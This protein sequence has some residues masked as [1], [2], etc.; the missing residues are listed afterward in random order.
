MNPLG[1]Y[2]LNLVADIESSID[3]FSLNE[4]CGL[5]SILSDNLG[6]NLIGADYKGIHTRVRVKCDALSASQTISLIKAM[7]DRIELKL[8]ET[9][10]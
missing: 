5:L 6:D 2:G 8:M 4:N 10:K 1:Y 3:E 9:A 7:C